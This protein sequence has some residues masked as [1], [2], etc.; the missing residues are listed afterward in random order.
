MCRGLGVRFGEREPADLGKI[1]L[2]V[3]KK[4]VLCKLLQILVFNSNL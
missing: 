3:E 2:S 1:I 4:K